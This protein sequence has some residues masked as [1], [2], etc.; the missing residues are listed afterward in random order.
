[1]PVTAKDTARAAYK[2]SKHSK[3]SYHGSA[4]RLPPWFEAAP[5]GFTFINPTGH[6]FQPRLESKSRAPDPAKR[7]SFIAPHHL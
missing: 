7:D 1:L 4:F 2:Q 5:A 6:E 3:H